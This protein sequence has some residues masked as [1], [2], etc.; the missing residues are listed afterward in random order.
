MNRVLTC[1]AAAMMLGSTGAAAP[2]TPTM[3]RPS[4]VSIVELIE[5]LM[6][7]TTDPPSER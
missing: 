3:G 7:I 5:E 4:V 6:A 2:V 1:V